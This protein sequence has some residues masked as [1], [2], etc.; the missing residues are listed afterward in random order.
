[1]HYVKK[2]DPRGSV[3]KDP[4]DD[5][6][7]HIWEASI[8]DWIKRKQEEDETWEVSFDEPPTEYDDVHSLELIPTLKVVFPAPSSTVSGDILNTDIRVSA[9]RG[10]TRVIYRVDQKYVGV[11]REHPFNLV[12]ETGGL[13]DGEHILTIIV[14][15]DI[16]N[17]IRETVPF[18]FLKQKDP[19]QKKEDL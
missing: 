15:D 16:G 18:T 4:N 1:M 6:Q 3:P 13:S 5:F 17:S 14:E 9:P 2:D 7:Y 10:I 11:V 12:Y 19:E 8:Q